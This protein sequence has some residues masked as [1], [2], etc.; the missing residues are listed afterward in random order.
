[1]I[2]WNSIIF[3][4]GGAINFGQWRRRVAVAYNSQFID[5]LRTQYPALNTVSKTALA[6]MLRDA[7]ARYLDEKHR[8]NTE[9]ALKPNTDAKS[10]H[11]RQLAKIANSAAQLKLQLAQLERPAAD[12]MW[13]PIRDSIT[14]IVSGNPAQ[15]GNETGTHNDGQTVP[16]FLLNERHLEQALW[17]IE[18]LASNAA[19]EL[20]KEIGGRPDHP[21]LRQWVEAMRRLW[22]GPLDQ[23]FTVTHSGY[24]VSRTFAFLS[25]AM[26]ALDPLI[27]ER[28][29][30]AVMRDVRDNPRSERTETLKLTAG[31]SARTGP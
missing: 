18:T 15:F 22:T 29:L 20:P 3:I 9:R 13:L 30:A 25:D 16:A 2:N 14:Q 24:G 1:M 10:R 27:E 28:T 12:L 11:R 4:R 26:N 19:D 8:T 21:G 23:K 6:K 31:D 7:G 5:Q 17:V